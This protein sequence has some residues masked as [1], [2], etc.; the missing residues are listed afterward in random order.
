MKYITSKVFLITNRIRHATFP[1]RWKISILL[2]TIYIL[3]ICSFTLY[4]PKINKYLFSIRSSTK[5]SDLHNVLFVSYFSPPYKSSYGTQRIEKFARYISK[6]NWRVLFLSTHPRRDYEIDKTGELLAQEIA[7]TRLPAMI[8]HPFRHR[9]LLPPDDFV[10]WVPDAIRG[11]RRI[12]E[13]SSV[14][15]IVA[16]APP[17][18]N[19]LAAAVCAIRADIPIVL[20]FRDPW[21]RIDA[22]WILHNKFARIVNEFLERKVV[23]ISSKI[24]IA[25]EKKYLSNYLI[26]DSKQ[27]SNKTITITN[28]YDEHDFELATKLPSLPEEN[29]KFI[30][31]YAGTFY[32]H[33]NFQNI[34]KILNWWSQHYPQDMSAVVFD[35]AGA[36]GQM[37]TGGDKFP[38]A[39]RDHGYISHLAAIQLRNHSTVQLF[40]LP[41]VFKA[42]IYSGKIFEMIRTEKPILALTRTDGAVAHLLSDTKTG[43]AFD[44]QDTAAAGQCLKDWF[45]E[46]KREGRVTYQGDA[47]RISNYARKNLAHR[48]AT[49]LGDVC[50][51]PSR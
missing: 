11:I 51:R 14:S 37:A 27:I 2:R 46:W 16:T 34:V 35:Y 48:L 5:K 29:E 7:V 30:I 25:D 8:D 36:N 13:D 24:I 6:L 20:D 45:D 33:E 42:H 38:I 1:W 23:S 44:P 15:T 28:G 31:S 17:Y 18:S 40:A 22:G 26:D 21:S 3:F 4:F 50:K 39:F 47:S 32:N 9:G 49:V 12:I 43:V 19:M 41:S 10:L